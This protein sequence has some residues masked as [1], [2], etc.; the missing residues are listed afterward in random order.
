MFESVDGLVDESDRR[1]ALET[2]MT[3][4]DETPESVYIIFID[5]LTD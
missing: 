3:N 5:R 4:E 2:D 1:R